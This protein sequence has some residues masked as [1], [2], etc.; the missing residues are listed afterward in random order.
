MAG[1]AAAY[2]IAPNLH[3]DE[4]AYVA[5][6][7]EAAGRRV[8]AGSATTR[9]PSP[10][11]PAMPH[12]LGKAEAE[13]LVR[14]SGLAWTILQPG[15]YLQNLD[16]TRHG[17]G[18]Y[19]VDAPFGFL[20]LADLG[21]PSRRCCR[22]TATWARRTSWPSRRASVAELAAEAGVDSRSSAEEWAATDGAGLDARVRDWL[23]AMF[24]YYDAPRPAG[25]HPAAARPARSLSRGTG[26]PGGP[27]C[28]HRSMR[29]EDSAVIAAP[30]STVWEVYSDVGHWPGDGLRHLRRA[31][32]PGPAA[33][34]LAGPDPP[35]PA[36]VAEW[37]VT[38][39][40]P[41]RSFTWVARG[42]GVRTTGTHVVE[43][44]GDGA[45]PPRSSTQ[46]GPLGPVVGLL[47][48]G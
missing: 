45:G 35:A 25:R 10:Y 41:G 2:V 8:S 22:R 13:D 4:P 37:T 47:T 26:G 38:E 29:F 3:P 24:A 18:A 46:G 40:D 32:R 15:V 5:Q 1:C 14:R 21:R 16:L 42:P 48:R 19:D 27:R 30:A 43:P 17:R 6:A 7:L 9:W 12:H 36:P 33:G 31:A 28:D 39:I 20:D 11:V 34:G 23:R 44:H